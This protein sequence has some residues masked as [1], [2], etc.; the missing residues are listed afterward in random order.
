MSAVVELE[1]VF[2]R[3]GDRTVLNGVSLTLCSGETLAVVGPSGSGKTSIL[4]LLLGFETPASGCVKL[5]GA[6][7]SEPGRILLPPEQRRLAPVFQDL[8]L[9]PHLT[10]AQ[11]LAFGLESQGVTRNERAARVEAMLHH[12]GLAERA[13]RLPG[14][15]S[16]GEQR[17]VAIAR[18]L[19]LQPRAVLLD[20]PLVN[21]DA[22]LRDELLRLFRSSFKE[23]GETALYVTHDL[24]EVVDLADRVAVIEGGQVIQLADLETLREHPASE[25]VRRLVADLGQAVGR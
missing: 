20:E 7:V 13:D 6:V 18:A 1:D 21:L 24:C 23:G 22:I 10:V 5:E 8:A 2:L 19:V 15:L 4:R 3:Y 16:G 12:V 11:H 25:F 17:R 14:T 9:W